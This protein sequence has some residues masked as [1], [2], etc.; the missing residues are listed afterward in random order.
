MNLKL[1]YSNTLYEQ[2]NLNKTLPYQETNP[3]YKRNTYAF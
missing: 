3:E 2:Q 1:K